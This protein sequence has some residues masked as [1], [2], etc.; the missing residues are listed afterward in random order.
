VTRVT[1]W[2]VI[3]LIAITVIAWNTITDA[4][5]LAV[6]VDEADLAAEAEDRFRALALA[7]VARHAPRGVSARHC[8]E[9]GDEIPEARRVAVPGCSRC[10]DCQDL[11]ERM[12]R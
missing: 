3:A 5:P 10:T 9:C 1:R 8:A 11:R 6:S 4:E 2:I 7:A 12:R